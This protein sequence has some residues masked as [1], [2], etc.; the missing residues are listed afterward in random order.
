MARWFITGSST[1]FGRVLTDRLSAAGHQVMAT[2]RKP[3]ALADAVAAGE[4][5]VLTHAVDVTDRAQVE[6]GFTAAIE[7]FGGIDVVVNNAGYGLMA[8]IEEASEE[9]IRRQ[10]DTNVLGAIRVMQL[11]AEHFRTRRAGV[12][13]N[14][15]SIAGLVSFPAVG[16]YAATKHALEA[17]S[18]ALDREGEALG[19]RSI[20][21]EPGPFRTDFHGRS[22]QLSAREIEEYAE[23]AGARKKMLQEASGRQAGDPER[24]AEIMMQ[25]AEHPNPPRRLL[26]G[27]MAHQTAL[28]KLA[29]M[30]ADIEAWEEITLSADF[31][32]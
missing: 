9:E 15:S 24:A 2:A 21:I 30:K 18:E 5:R 13:F 23:T 17:L 8:A 20:A 14:L 12:I 11:S 3:E 4:G 31:P 26:L 22:L 16:F 19:F 7:A 10:F 28:D 29:A 32:S 27:A 1:G 25:L 6:A